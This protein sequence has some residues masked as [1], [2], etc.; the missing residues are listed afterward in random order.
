MLL[1]VDI[2]NSNIKFGVF[3]GETLLSKR[4]FPTRKFLLSVEPASL[5]MPEGISA[6]IASSVVPEADDK[7]AK[8]VREM[9]GAE[10]AFVS[11]EW[12]L[13]FEINYEPPGSIG[14]DRL[15]NLFAAIEKYGPPCIVCSLGT[16]VTIDVVNGDKA[17]IGGLIAPGLETLS[18]ALHLN[19]SKLPEIELELPDQLIQN[20]TEGS[21]RSG[22]VNGFIAMVEGLVSGSKT[23]LG[24]PAK[25]IGTGGS[26][27]LVAENSSVLDLVDEN[28]LLDGLRLLYEKR[29]PA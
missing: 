6:C 28:L 23:E 10:P 3:D 18:K 5:N 8:V 22:I 2:G 7:I 19:T 9:T 17:F 29:Q 12:D 24:E 11:N 14:T 4:S 1:A 25:V 26:A 16:A 27:A 13:G 15:V 20:S 21:I